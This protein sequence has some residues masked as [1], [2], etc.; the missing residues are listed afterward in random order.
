MFVRL[1]LQISQIV[2]HADRLRRPENI[3]FPP[4]PSVLYQ[5]LL[6]RSR[7]FPLSV[8]VGILGTDP[9]SREGERGVRLVVVVLLVV[10]I[11]AQHWGTGSQEGACVLTLGGHGT[12]EQGSFDS[13]IFAKGS[14]P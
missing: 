4:V 12:F 11:S 6:F 9:T 2:R 5:F 13:I 7:T 8:M 14:S 10:G 3:I 1:C